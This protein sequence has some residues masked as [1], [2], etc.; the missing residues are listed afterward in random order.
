[1]SY[2]DEHRGHEAFCVS[3]CNWTARSAT[4]EGARVLAEH[5]DRNTRRNAAGQVQ[6]FGHATD[7]RTVSR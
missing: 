6:P 1:M 5:H 4:P 7:V 2:P 3:R